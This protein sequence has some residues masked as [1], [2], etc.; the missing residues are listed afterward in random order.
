M[1]RAHQCLLAAPIRAAGARIWDSGRELSSQLLLRADELP[2]KRVLELGAGTGIGG[3]TA[4]ACGAECVLSD[5]AELL[6]L[7][8]Q[9]I[10]ANEL[11][12]S[13][14]AT[15]LLWGDAA[16]M[17]RVG[18][19]GPFDL[20]CGSDL[21]YAPHIFPLLVETLA[22]LC[23]PGQTEVLLTYPTRYTEDLFFE[24]AAMHFE[25]DDAEMVG[26]NV[27]ATWMRLLKDE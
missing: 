23:T 21:L 13:A 11:Q 20:V 12:L 7:L 10:Q 22:E 6:P 9:N 17:E 16:D 8:N 18:A 3:L 26:C 24:E 25:V 4:A 19:S 15:Q 1:T 5:Q 27:W 14:M 2:G